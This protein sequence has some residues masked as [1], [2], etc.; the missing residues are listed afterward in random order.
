MSNLPVISNQ[1]F[2]AINASPTQSNIPPH[3]MPKHLIK[4]EVQQPQ[5]VL[6]QKSIDLMIHRFEAFLN[7][8]NQS[9][10]KERELRGVA[11]TNKQNPHSKVETRTKKKI[12]KKKQTP[13]QKKDQNQEKSPIP[14]NKD[15]EEFYYHINKLHGNRNLSEDEFIKFCESIGSFPINQLDPNYKEKCK[16][17]LQ[18]INN[19]KK[20]ENVEFINTKLPENILT[21]INKDGTK[22]NYSKLPEN[23]GHIRISYFIWE[24]QGNKEKDSTA[25]GRKIRKMHFLMKNKGE[26]SGEEDSEERGQILK[27]DN[28][29]GKK[30]G[31]TIPDALKENKTNKRYDN[32]TP[33]ED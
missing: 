10:R 22:P 7:N 24:N 21:Y 23:C 3:L 1:P 13:K 12:A 14:I 26:G 28:G 5:T 2:P 31:E 25:I 11:K 30:I 27:E 29:K 18:T 16:Q 20:K 6:D 15:F 33:I 17:I 8:V 4:K 32:T 19:Y 9:K